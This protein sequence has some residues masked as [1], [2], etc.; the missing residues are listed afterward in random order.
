MRRF[1]NILVTTDFSPASRPAVSAALALAGESRGKVW[2]AHAVPPI[3]RGS[4]PRMYQE[5]DEFLRSHATRNLKRLAATAN[6]RGVRTES[7]LLQGL[8]PEAVT[9]AARA[10][11]AELVVVG[12]HGR[13]GAARVFLGSVAARIVATAPCPVLSVKRK[14]RRAAPRTVVFATDFSRA[15]APAWRTALALARSAGAR[16]RIVHVQKPLAEGQP[17]RWAYAEAERDLLAGARKGLDRL[18]DAARKTGVRADAAVLRGVAHEEIG[19]AA[20]KA[21]DAWIVVGTHGRTG[22]SGALLGSVAARVVATAP[23]PVLTVRAPK[24]R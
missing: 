1:R 6:A 22:L 11:H 19:R 9:R 10:R 8:A 4:A 20:R 15:S 14:P 17:L 18:R 3:P 7:L 13:T 12:T 24:G 5:M 16:L 21:P 23:C 2:I